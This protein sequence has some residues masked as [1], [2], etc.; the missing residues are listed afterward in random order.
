[1][2]VPTA[3][4]I[5][6]RPD[7]TNQR[8]DFFWSAPTSDG[9]NPITGYTLECAAIAYSA[10][11][12]PTT[13]RAAVTGLTNGTTYTF[14]IY[15]TNGIGN[16]PIATFRS[17]QPGFT[18][19]APTALSAIP[20]SGAVVDVGWTPPAYTGVASIGWYLVSAF[21]VDSSGN[22]PVIQGTQGYTTNRQLDLL[23]ATR[24]YSILVQAINDPGYSP[25]TNYLPTYTPGTLPTDISGANLTLWLD[26]SDMTTL[27]RDTAGTSRIDREFHQ[28]RRWNDKS[29][30]GH[31]FTSVDAVHPASHTPTA[32]NGALPAVQFTNGNQK[33]GCDAFTV[34]PTNRFSMFAVYRYPT[35][36]TGA[37]VVQDTGTNDLVNIFTD[38]SGAGYAVNVGTDADSRFPY[39]AAVTVTTVTAGAS[40]ATATQVYPT[41]KTITTARGGDTFNTSTGFRIGVAPSTTDIR[42]SELIFYNVALTSSQVTSIQNYLTRKWSISLGASLYFSGAAN[43]YL[44]VANDADLRM[45]TGDFTIEWFQYMQTGQ[46]FPRIFSIGT[47]PGADI[48]VSIEGGS[49]FYLWVNNSARLVTSSFSSY[50]QWVHVAIVGTGG[51]QIKVYINGSLINTS[52][53]YNLTNST[54]ALT[55]GNE[56]SP[57]SGGAYKGYLTNF[58]WTKGTAVY[59]GAFTVPTSPLPALAN[60]KLLLLAATAGS[61]T[62]DSSSAAKTVTNNGGNVTWNALKPF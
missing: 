3:P 29:G 37:Y 14:T 5:F 17:V 41:A 18:P 28:V 33:L 19:D 35:T 50:D 30:A 20:V 4:Q 44:T 15:A 21:P 22:A 25:A 46:S 48:A 8:L 13:F 61:A 39:N 54:N 52:G 49:S 11:F 51:S 36:G 62:T 10:S 24:S 32:L 31:H 40:T 1:M 42:L 23:D 34:S 58:R 53:S 43:A 56:T 9:G 55:I 27:Y 57:S 45:G 2:S 6:I 59:T 47:Y 38:V 12:G 7:A 26:A 60:T 16:S